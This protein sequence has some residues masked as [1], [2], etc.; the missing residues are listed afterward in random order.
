MAYPVCWNPVAVEIVQINKTQTVAERLDP[1]FGEPA[2]GQEKVYTSV[3]NL[4]AQ[5]AYVKKDEQEAALTGDPAMADGHLTFRARDLER[6]GIVLQKGDVVR[7]IAGNPVD[8]K[9]LEVR[10]QAHLQG[11]SWLTMAFFG[12]NEET[13]PSIRR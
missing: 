10:P 7:R 4:R 2:Y 9:I 11:K 5:I 1:D 6:D 8:F 13:R 12:P 3:L